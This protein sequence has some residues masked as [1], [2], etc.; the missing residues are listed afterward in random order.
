MLLTSMEF[1]QLWTILPYIFSVESGGGEGFGGGGV[2]SHN[3]TPDRRTYDASL[4]DCIL[5]I[6]Y[7]H[8]LALDRL[9]ITNSRLEISEYP[10]NTK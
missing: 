8:S 4:V 2:C 9:Q 3:R 1:D 7:T 10:H 6:L 5:N